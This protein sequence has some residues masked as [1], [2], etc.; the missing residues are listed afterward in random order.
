[1]TKITGGQAV[2][3]ALRAE[4]VSR[5]FGLIGSAGMEIF[6]A[7]YDAPTVR[8][9]GVRDERTGVL[10]ADGYARASG[11]AG[12]F[13]PAKNGPGATNLVTGLARRT[14]PTRR[15]WL[16]PGLAS[17]HAT[18][19]RKWTSGRCSSPSPRRPGR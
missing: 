18:P 19:S 14:P 1:M 17:A 7:L 16:S 10:M 12:V 4:G 5:V 9:I 13:K 15:W 11:K 6:D 2:V 8:F 3:E